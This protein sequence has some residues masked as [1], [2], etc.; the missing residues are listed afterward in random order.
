SYHSWPE[1]VMH[2]DTKTG[3]VI[4]AAGPEIRVTER[5]QALGDSP[6]SKALA[7]WSKSCRE[8]L[9]RLSKEP[10]RTENRY[11]LAAVCLAPETD[12]ADDSCIQVTAH[13]RILFYY[14]SVPDKS[15]SL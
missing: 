5:G 1:I 15:A 9:T 10:R 12:C 14:L 7:S 2:T 11:L 13:S 8:K 4:T 6:T 3:R